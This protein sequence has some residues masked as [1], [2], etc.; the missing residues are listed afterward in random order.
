MH[1]GM[2]AKKQ[3]SSVEF[4]FLEL[5]NY[6]QRKQ[7]EGGKHHDENDDSYFYQMRFKRLG[8]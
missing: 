5:A 7:G 8:P 3:A 6:C 2:L 1:D 4:S